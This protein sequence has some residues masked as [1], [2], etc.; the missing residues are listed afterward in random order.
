MFYLKRLLKGN[1]YKK[2]YE[3]G[4]RQSIVGMIV[5]SVLFANHSYFYLLY[6]TASAFN[7]K[8]FIQLNYK[9]KRYERIVAAM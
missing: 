4:S 5:S 3:S 8:T 1:Y 7:S 6:M 2:N 9:F